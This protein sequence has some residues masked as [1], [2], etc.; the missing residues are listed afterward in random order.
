M[1]LLVTGVVLA[2]NSAYA[3]AAMVADYPF[4]NSL[5]SEVSGAPDLVDLGSGVYTT[6]TVFGKADCPVF[7]FEDNPE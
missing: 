1:Q 2:F 7:E 4:D 6:D 3:Q 5:A